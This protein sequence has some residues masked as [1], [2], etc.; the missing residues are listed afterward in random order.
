[1]TVAW[2]H[3]LSIPPRLHAGLGQ[4]QS[5]TN[6]SGAAGALA[7]PGAVE[8]EFPIFRKALQAVQRSQRLTSKV[9]ALTWQQAR[10]G[11][12]PTTLTST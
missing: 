9:V 7:K 4:F 5:F 2:D 10:T 1:M 12:A 11:P 8:V 6:S 3:T